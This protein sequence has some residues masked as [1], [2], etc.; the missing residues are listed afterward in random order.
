MP[1]GFFDEEDETFSGISGH[2]VKRRDMNLE[3][4]NFYEEKQRYDVG[5]SDTYTQSK[6]REE[7]HE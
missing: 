3:Q 4:M 7:I 6:Q 5:A 2:V 1:F